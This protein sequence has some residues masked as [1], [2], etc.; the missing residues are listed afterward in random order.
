MYLRGMNCHG[1][2]IMDFTLI[3]FEGNTYEFSDL[4]DMFYLV[5]CSL[6]NVSRASI[7]MPVMPV[8]FDDA[9]VP[10]F[11]KITTRHVHVKYSSR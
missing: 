8:L 5:F 2:P 6:K 7:T 9:Y 10:I 4:C 1:E 11:S 3:F